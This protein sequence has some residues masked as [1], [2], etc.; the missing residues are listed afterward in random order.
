M[1]E[2]TESA[3]LKSRPPLSDGA[4]TQ[5]ETTI[6]TH[7]HTKTTTSGHIENPARMKCASDDVHT[8]TITVQHAT[9][10]A[11]MLVIISRT[12]QTLQDN[13][14]T[15]VQFVYVFVLFLCTSTTTPC[16]SQMCA[17]EIELH[18]AVALAEAETSRKLVTTND[19][20]VQLLHLLAFSWF[21]IFDHFRVAVPARRWLVHSISRAFYLR[22]RQ[23]SRFA[24]RAFCF[25]TLNE[26]LQRSR[27]C[28][29]SPHNPKPVAKHLLSFFILLS[30]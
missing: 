2:R 9:H 28:V 27:V 5:N 11:A 14:T 25:L 10:N 26:H 1:K 15:I 20:S 19:E 16:A 29:R 13:E 6:W 17:K 12:R 22:Q 23:W 30:N 24:M 4:G 8:G 18:L 21:V 3:Y 7:A